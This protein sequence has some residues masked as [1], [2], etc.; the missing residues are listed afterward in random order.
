[1]E[2]NVNLKQTSAQL[3]SA[4][5]MQDRGTPEFIA[6]CKAEF[7]ERMEMIVRVRDPAVSRHNLEALRNGKLNFIVTGGNNE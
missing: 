4:A 5:L 3:V 2:I 1:M 6:S 7:H